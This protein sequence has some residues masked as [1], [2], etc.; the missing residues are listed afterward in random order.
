MR[1][2]ILDE[3]FMSGTIAARALS[4]AGC[5][6]DVIAATGGH[7]RCAVDGCEWRLAPRVGDRALLDLVEQAVA[8][9]R[10]DVVYPV[11]EPLQWLLWDRAPRWEALIFPHVAA[12]DRPPRRDKRLMSE[13][14]RRCGVSVPAE[15]PAKTDELVDAAA[16]DLGL[17]LVIKGSTG[18]GGRNTRVCAS[19]AEARRAARE[20][21][22][23]GYEPFA[24]EYVEGCTALAG[25]LF[26][27]G[28]AL[29]FYAG[30]KTT[31]HP[32]RVGPAAELL[33]ADD[34]ELERVALEGFGAAR[35]TGIASIDLIRDRAGRYHFLELN[36]RPWGSI[37][38]ALASGVDLFEALAR[39]WRAE[40]VTPRLSFRKNLGIPV[41]PLYALSAAYWRSGRAFRPAVHDLHRMLSI[42]RAEPALA[43]HVAHR[44]L[45]VCLNW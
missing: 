43:A 21:R 45:R 7:G 3:G 35:I 41:F 5:R 10:H 4:S 15:R 17:P 42:L 12:S 9:G 33:S 18:R 25:G 31:Q 11:T 39:Y 40:R 37:E 19:R 26:D 29:R 2:L 22:D 20:L 13:L 14:M 1:V 44:F 16:R 23:R 30:L 6:V 27:Q 38:A 34:G 24:Q 8:R 28:R 36:P 32:P